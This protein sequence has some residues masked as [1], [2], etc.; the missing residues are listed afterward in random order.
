VTRYKPCGI[1]LDLRTE[2]TL[3]VDELEALDL[4][5]L[6]NLHHVQAGERMGVS[7]ATFG[8]ILE[9]AR[10]KV[11]LALRSGFSLRIDGG[12]YE[13]IMTRNFVCA[14]CGHCWESEQGRCHTPGCPRCGSARFGCEHKPAPAAG[15]EASG[16]CGDGD[17]HEHKDGAC[18]CH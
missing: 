4:A 18:G 13:V 15:T 9:S 11:I 1:P 14:D 6:Q 12:T 5:D 10:K 2:I 16:C 17:H 7:R 3:A 8:R